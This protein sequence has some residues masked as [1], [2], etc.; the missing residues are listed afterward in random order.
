MLT[1]APLQCSQPRITTTASPGNGVADAKAI[2]KFGG[3]CNKVNF[4]T[5]YIGVNWGV[6]EYDD[7]KAFDV[8]SDD[9]CKQ[10]AAP[11]FYEPTPGPPN[12]G[13]TCYNMTDTGPWKSMVDYNTN[14]QDDDT[15]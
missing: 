13:V 10:Q 6:G 1:E 2:P 14:R 3:G 7:M 8:F 12:N 15:K 11:R 5:N 9:N 4:A